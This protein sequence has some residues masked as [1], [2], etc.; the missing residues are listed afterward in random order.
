MAKPA[1]TK[2]DDS[3]TVVD[4]VLPLALTFTNPYEEELIKTAKT[5]GTPGKGILAADESTGTIGKRLASIG[6]KNEEVNRRK[7]RQLLFTTPDLEK[8]ISG[9]IMY[10]ETLRQKSDKNIAFVD[11]LKKKGIITGIKTDKV[12]A[13]YRHYIPIIYGI[14][15][16]IDNILYVFGFILCVYI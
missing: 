2:V 10:D 15:C 13:I 5:I 8:Y 4:E 16:Y 7:Y 6:V 1:E 14:Y 3:E 9:V 12:C 11:I